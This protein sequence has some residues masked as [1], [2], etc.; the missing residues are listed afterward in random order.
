VG[1][2]SGP[3]GALWIENS[4]LHYIDAEGHERKTIR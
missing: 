4:M 3:K 2:S 1:Q